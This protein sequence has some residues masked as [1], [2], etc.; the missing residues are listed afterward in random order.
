MFTRT[1]E[2][3]P[4]AVVG[5]GCCPWLGPAD[6]VWARCCPPLPENR[7]RLPDGGSRECAC[8]SHD[9]LLFHH[10]I[11]APMS[12]LGRCRT[13]R[14]ASSALGRPAFA[15]PRLR[16]ATAV[17]SC[18]GWIGDRIKV[19][20]TEIAPKRSGLHHGTSGE[21]T[22]LSFP[23]TFEKGDAAE[24]RL[25]HPLFKARRGESEECSASASKC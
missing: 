17:G 25:A 23:C 3:C 9:L 2:T 4:V 21:P 20:E 6:P 11:V 15:A 16:P 14:V 13:G 1:L 19:N 24:L 8:R 10:R 18:F 12:V 5:F 22:K 7:L